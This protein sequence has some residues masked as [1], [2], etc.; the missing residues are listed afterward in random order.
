MSYVYISKRFINSNSHLLRVEKGYYQT[1]YRIE[2]VEMPII[3]A[4]QGVFI[5]KELFINK[6]STFLYKTLDK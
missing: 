2:M 1:F 3:M 4:I 5:N 6:T